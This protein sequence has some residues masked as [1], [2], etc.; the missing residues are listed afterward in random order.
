MDAQGDRPGGEGNR[1]HYE[2]LVE[3]ATVQKI[4][5]LSC[6]SNE[7]NGHLISTALWTGLLL[8]DLLNEA[9]VKPAVVE[10]PRRRRL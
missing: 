7:L 9:G 6:I 2:Q 10:V 5:T 1:A 3:R 8:A 4:T